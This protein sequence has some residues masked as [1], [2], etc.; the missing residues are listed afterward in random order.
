MYDAQVTLF[1]RIV[2]VKF[3]FPPNR[4][5][6]Q[7]TDLISKLIVKKPGNRIGCSATSKPGEIF[8]H[9]FFTQ[10]NGILVGRKINAPWVPQIKSDSDTA[11]FDNYSVEER[12]EER[13]R[14]R[15][16]KTKLTKEQQAL[17]DAF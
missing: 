2:Q 3:D 13:S 8:D 7:S 10:E 6:T 12:E 5:T 11:N 1:K 4:G 16:K 17:F 15:K 9:P 14:A